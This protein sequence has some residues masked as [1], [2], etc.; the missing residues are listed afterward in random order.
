MHNIVP[1]REETKKKVTHSWIYEYYLFIFKSVQ[2]IILNAR[3]M[4][5]RANTIGI[6]NMRNKMSS[7]IEIGF[8]CLVMVFWNMLNILSHRHFAKNIE[9]V[10]YPNM[11][12]HTISRHHKHLHVLSLLDNM[13]HDFSNIVRNCVQFWG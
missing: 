6:Q 5:V 2:W 1:R 9:R 13:K 11:N 10:T 3:S 7:T 4:E 12:V 8:F